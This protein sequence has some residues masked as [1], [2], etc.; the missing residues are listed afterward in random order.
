MTGNSQPRVFDALPPQPMSA[1]TVKELGKSD[2]V[3]GTMPIESR[4]NDII[5]EFILYFN[6]TM[7]AIAFDPDATTWHVLESRPINES[8]LHELEDE[9][10]DLLYEWRE[11]HVLPYLVENDLIPNFVIE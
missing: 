11:E 7:Y 2:A 3:D 10:M 1:E 6:D 8:R 9:L 5:T 4:F